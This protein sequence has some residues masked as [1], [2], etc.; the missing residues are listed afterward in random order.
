MKL[1]IGF[2]DFGQVKNNKYNFIDKSLFIKE[3]LDDFAQVSVITRPRRFGKT[4]NLSMLHYFL[5]ADVYGGKTQ[6]LFDDLNIAKVDNGAYMQHQGK[7]PVVAITFKNIKEESFDAAL[8]KFKL[9]IQELYRAHYYLVDSKQL[10]E[11]EKKSF[12]QYLADDFNQ[13]VA[14]NALYLLTELVS[15]HYQQKVWL[16]I[17]EYDTPIQAGYLNNHY[18][19]I[20]K[21]MRDVFSAA[22]KNNRYLERAVVTGILRISKESLFSGINNLIVYSVLQTKY[23]QYFGFTE[24]EVSD[25]LKQTNLTSQEQEIKKWYNGYIFGHT[26]VYNPWS[27]VNCIYDDGVLKPYWGNTSDNV[28]IKTLVIKSAPEFKQQIA[29]LLQ[30]RII[31]KNIDDNMVFGDLHG[32]PQAAWSL[33][34]MSG[35]LKVVKATVI[36]GVTVCELAI[37]NFEVKILYRMMV[38][39]WLGNGNGAEWYQN[40]LTYLLIGDIESF[41]QNFGQVLVRTVSVHDA[42]HHPEAFYHG[43]ILG[44]AAGLDQ[45]K[46]ELRSNKESGLGRY[47]IAIIPR[48]FNKL[49][50]I[51]EIKSIAPPKLTKKKL[52]QYLELELAKAAQIALEQINNKQ[53]ETELSQRGIKNTLKIGLAFSGKDFR[54]VCQA[55]P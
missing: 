12:I 50:I 21:F 33:L 8:R 15:K 47:D 25:I 5:A 29:L 18:K 10:N 31:M 22:L 27:I 46:Y 16:L 24:A 44:L 53:Y 52:A 41:S 11:Y 40:F 28:L 51:F 54:L 39:S 30:D 4:F 23:S 7:Y 14:E 34:L 43:F 55:L 3:V 2:D 35:Y 1:Q 45:T 37:P 26:T 17:D 13:A 38:R 6:G 32:D 48:D 9:L 20:V 19:D 42:A 36:E 49:A